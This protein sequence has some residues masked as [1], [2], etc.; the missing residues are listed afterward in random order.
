MAGI[1][2]DNSTVDQW[3]DCAAAPDNNANYTVAGW[4]KEDAD[5]L[6]GHILTIGANPQNEDFLRVTDAQTRRLFSKVG[7]ALDIFQSGTS[8]SAGWSHWSL[9]RSGNDL[10]WRINGVV[11]HSGTNSDGAIAGRTTATD[12]YIGRTLTYGV[13]D[14]VHAFAGWACW[15]RALTAAELER[16]ARDYRAL[17][18]DSLFGEWP[19][20]NGDL[21]DWSGNGNDWTAT[22]SPGASTE[23]PGIAFASQPIIV[24]E[25]A[26]ASGVSASISG[27]LATVGGAAVGK[28]VDTATITGTITTVSASAVGESVVTVAITGTLTTVVA[29]ATG[30][31]GAI[32]GDITGALPTVGG[33]AVGVPVATGEV[34]G[35]L[36][37]VDAS[38]FGETTVTVEIAGGLATVVA[39]ASGGHIAVAAATVTGA[40]PTVVAS[41]DSH[42]R[43]IMSSDL[44]DTASFQQGDEWFITLE[45]VSADSPAA[46]IVIVFE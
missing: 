46:R 29:A 36:P 18:R 42:Y 39:T 5:S 7:G 25:A 28:P 38:A 45:G 40:L 22:G 20:L 1:V 2:L 3:L 10:T 8:S 19:F 12:F 11:I 21:T 17:S 15:T 33:S 23:G 4:I 24:E 34:T 41:A 31:G 14:G 30:G 27:A 16:E 37:I 32:T 43:V 35:G 13:S 6:E 26:A 44:A 9:V